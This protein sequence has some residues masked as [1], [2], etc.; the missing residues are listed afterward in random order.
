MPHTS[1]IV[2]S[3]IGGLATL[4]FV[5]ALASLRLQRSGQTSANGRPKETVD[6][7]NGQPKETVDAPSDSSLQTE[8]K[9]LDSSPGQNPEPDA[10]SEAVRALNHVKE[11]VA[12]RGASFLELPID[13][14]LDVVN[15]CGSDERQEENVGTVLEALEALESKTDSAVILLHDLLAAASSN[16]GEPSATEQMHGDLVTLGSLL[17]NLAASNKRILGQ[18]KPPVEDHRAAIFD[19]IRVMVRDFAA[20]NGISVEDVIAL[21]ARVNSATELEND[22]ATVQL[23][24]SPDPAKGLV[25]IAS[26]SNQTYGLLSPISEGS[27]SH[28]EVETE[29]T[30]GMNIYMRF[31]TGGPIEDLHEAINHYNNALALASS[32]HP[33]R[34]ELL[35][36]AGDALF[37][38]FERLGRME[39]LEEAIGHHR[40]VHALLPLDHPDRS[41]F[42]IDFAN[43]LQTRFG[44]LGQIEDLE[45]A[46][47]HHRGA[48]EQ[49]PPGHVDRFVSLHNLAVVMEKRFGQLGLMQD[50]EEAVILN[51]EAL[52]LFPPQHLH[53]PASLS[54]LASA[55]HTR[56]EHSGRLE[57]LEELISH[58]RDTL[59]SC[60]PDDPDRF[61]PLNNY[62]N[63]MLT[64][65]EHTL[66]MSDLQEAIDQLRNALELCPPDH[67][68]RSGLLVNLANALGSRFRQSGQMKDLDEAIG[69]QRSA[70][71]LCPPGN[72][73]RSAS[74][75]NL[76]AILS[77]RFQELSQMK[78]L[79]AA[80]AC[81]RDA[82]DLR[83]PGHFNRPSSL[84]NLGAALHNRFDLLGQSV[85]LEEAVGYHRDAL[86]LRPPGHPDRNLSLGNL[87]A[88]M[89]TRFEQLGRK[90]DL[91]EAIRLLHSGAH[92]DCETPGRRYS[93]ALQL[94]ALLEAHNRPLALHAFGTAL[95]LLQ[96]SL[97]VY[98]DGE[99]RR[100]ALSAD[101]L[102]PSLAISAAALAIE[103]GNLE[104]AVEFLD[105]GRGLLWSNIRGFR[106]PLEEVHR[107]DPSLAELFREK[108]DQLEALATS[109]PLGP[110]Q[111]AITNPHELK[112]AYEA[113]CARQR[114]LSSERED[115][116]QQIRRLDGFEHFLKAV[117]FQELQNAA[118][119]GP[120]I[121]VNV[122][123]QRSDVI[124]LLPRGTPI[125]H[126]LSV[127]G[128]NREAAYST[129]LELSDLL[130]EKR[131][132]PG[133]SSVLKN[134]ILKKLADTLV[135]PILAKL[136]SLK[137]QPK[138]RIWWCPTS[139]LCALP[140]HA[141]GH[142]PKT[143]ISSYTPTLSA[144]NAARKSRDARPPA[145]VAAGTKPALLAIIHPGH[146]PRTKDEPDE[147]LRTILT[148]R[149]VIEKTGGPG[150]V[151]SMVQSDATRE[152]VLSA[153]SRHPWFYFG[154]H[155]RLNSTQPPQ[156]GFELEGVALTLA[157]LA[158]ARLPNAEFAFLAACDSAITGSTASTPNEALHLAA[159]VQF[160]GMG[161]V[162]GTLWPMADEDGPKVAQVFWKHMF[163]ENDARKSAEAL[164]KVVAAMR[165]KTGPW[166]KAV[167]ESG[168]LQRWA[169]YIHI[170]A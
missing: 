148:E 2:G 123:P 92:D 77:I 152:T 35:G 151:I 38:R 52:G 71:E 163:Q 73:N 149:N 56:Y 102:S 46:I 12:G 118:A 160:C 53:R 91:L 166:A 22:G 159:A 41:Y 50:I 8:E 117:P 40:S 66:Q 72:P 25:V 155:G 140:I 3:I 143:Y 67:I 134:T 146:L 133:F 21:A 110:I 87:A 107:V 9:E 104:K 94:T 6:A 34:P 68:N 131:G 164:Q 19:P 103:Q 29:K 54:N 55:M 65:F 63:A 126:P 125:L 121:V 83:P 100:E 43:A 138:S 109:S 157:D 144:L 116:I 141:A 128:R 147:M 114:Q 58:H 142:L 79:E 154:C 106:Q 17:A 93:C 85:D 33:L 165:T 30:V 23:T 156:S 51:R 78:D 27:E 37:T 26:Q 167:G 137:V 39:D 59:Q 161:G 99:L 86:D 153:L 24:P 132:K 61:L 89:R 111:P 74:L 5:T 47:V 60:P 98:P 45:E 76:A 1:I 84:N 18:A 48:L 32:D 20:L 90:E 108:S 139:V 15:A 112:M 75:N 14:L 88:A 69:H 44:I 11:L 64:R 62:A 169:N 36:D 7:P 150:R 136:E 31:L 135:T 124:I 95:N 16:H 162:V 49:R 129:F 81:H 127:D 122:A 80:I 70:L 42:L 97:A 82:L 113:R 120:I 10:F 170:G 96:L 168:S 13:G 145:Q 28:D 101:H 105:Q 57:D 130:F 158:Q 4:G 115:V 119:E